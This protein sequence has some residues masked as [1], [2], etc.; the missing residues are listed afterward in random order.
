[1][2]A[3]L[4]PVLVALILGGCGMITVGNGDRVAPEQVGPVFA[5]PEGDGPPIECRGLDRE[6]CLIPGAIEDTVPGFG[7]DVID[8]VIVSCVGRCSPDNGEYRIDIVVDGSTQSIGGG[9]YGSS[10][11]GP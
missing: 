3:R 2:R 8:R 4:A 11:A 7:F 9:A 6:Q 1:M 5:R 10:E